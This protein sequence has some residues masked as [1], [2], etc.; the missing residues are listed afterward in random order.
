[1]TSK[2]EELGNKLKKYEDYENLKSEGLKREN[3]MLKKRLEQVEGDMQL[4]IDLK[5]QG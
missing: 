2:N 4:M 1:M 3:E 5:D